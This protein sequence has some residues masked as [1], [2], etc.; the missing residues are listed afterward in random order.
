MKFF[1]TGL[2]TGLA[3]GYLTAPRP[4]KETRDQLRA[5][6]NRQ[7]RT[8]NEQWSKT[9]AQAKQLAD[10]AKANLGSSK[11]EPNL[12]ADLEAGKLDPYL[13]APWRA[14]HTHPNQVENP[15]D[16]APAT[17]DKAADALPK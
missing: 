4:G 10:S 2:A 7:T 3:V 5:A 1:L 15:A 8:L 11:P 16:A 12:F 6:A 13:D 9:V 14:M 17:A